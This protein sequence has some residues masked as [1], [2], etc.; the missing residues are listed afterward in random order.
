M[1]VWLMLVCAG[2]AKF[3]TWKY[4]VNVVVD[5]VAFKAAGAVGTAAAL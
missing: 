1:A 5:Q 2:W 4:P 3:M